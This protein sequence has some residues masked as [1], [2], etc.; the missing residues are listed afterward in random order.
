MRL[1]FFLPSVRLQWQYFCLLLILRVHDK[2]I[3]LFPCLLSPP[4]PE[5][6]FADLY[7][8][9]GKRWIAN[10]AVLQLLNKKQGLCTS[11]GMSLKG[12]LGQWLSVL[13]TTKVADE[14]PSAKKRIE[15]LKQFY[16][17]TLDTSRGLYFYSP[18]SMVWWIDPLTVCLF[19]PLSMHTVKKSVCRRFCFI[20]NPCIY[21]FLLRLVTCP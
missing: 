3:C 7:S 6:H 5:F 20:F 19:L 17:Q 14:A 10:F 9:S 4:T 21:S 2:Y 11:E 1:L 15:A 18:D 16:H 12:L 13:L 8:F